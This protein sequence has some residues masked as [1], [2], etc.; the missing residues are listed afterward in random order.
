MPIRKVPSTCPASDVLDRNGFYSLR[1]HTQH[2]HH[3]RSPRRVESSLGVRAHRP[4][5]G[6]VC[7][8]LCRWVFRPYTSVARGARKNWGKTNQHVGG[9]H[10]ASSNGN[11]SDYRIRDVQGEG[12]GGENETSEMYYFLNGNS[13]R[14]K[15]VF[16]HKS[17]VNDG[18]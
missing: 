7:I 12:G 8:L 4:R 5:S 10:W 14:K 6:V 17:L 13:T 16:N 15:S 9:R 11:R 2:I 3:A 1:R 18:V